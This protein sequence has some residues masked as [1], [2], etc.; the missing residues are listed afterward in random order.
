[1]KK[2]YVF[3]TVTA[4]IKSI[5]ADAAAM[6]ILTLAPGH[7]WVEITET[8]AK[9]IAIAVNKALEPHLINS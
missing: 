5:V 6:A 3:N 9:H 1:M 8:E 7:N 4:E 2:I